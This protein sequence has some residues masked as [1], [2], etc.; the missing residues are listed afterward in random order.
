MGVKF[1][2]ASGSP[3]RKEIFDTFGIEYKVI[4][5][6]AE[7]DVNTEGMSPEQTVQEL[8]L[9]KGRAVAE[10][11]KDEEEHTYIVVSADTVVASRNKILGKPGSRAE[12]KKMLKA[13]SGK[14]H[15]VLTGVCIWKIHPGWVTKGCTVAEKTEVYF[16]NLSD[17]L[18]EAYLDTDEYKDKAG[19][20]GIQGKGAVLVEK[21]KGDYLNVVGFPVNKFYEIL[22]EEFA[23]DLNQAEK[24]L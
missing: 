17:E 9:A 23:L 11:F 4:T 1:V 2:L 7:E 22:K 21:I 15:S 8:A 5:T 20:Y 12:A 14:K 18:I 3:R 19:S 13:L 10:M 24:S 6:D 16:K